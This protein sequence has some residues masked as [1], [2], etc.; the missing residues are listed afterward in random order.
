MNSTEFEK[1][2]RE[3]KC[4]YVWTHCT[5]IASRFHQAQNR[6]LRINLFYNGQFFIEVWYN[7]EHAYF[8][9][10][11]SFEDRKLLEPYIDIINLNEL[12]VH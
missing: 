1:L 4:R 10:I 2:P 7:S 5:F 9:D 6:K 11:K 3:K 8:G 12:M